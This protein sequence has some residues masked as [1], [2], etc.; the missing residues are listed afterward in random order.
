MRSIEI[1]NDLIGNRTRDLPACM[2]NYL[3]GNSRGLLKILYWHLPRGSEGSQETFSQDSQCLGRDL[4]R[5]PP[6]YEA[7][8]LA[9]SQLVLLQSVNYTSL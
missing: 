3:E 8:A 9:L 5:A 4:I 7:R 2:M 1:S 6:E